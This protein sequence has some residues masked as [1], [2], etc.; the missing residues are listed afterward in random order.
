MSEGED[1]SFEKLQIEETRLHGQPEVRIVDT[2]LNIKSSE[3]SLVNNFSDN[4]MSPEQNKNDW[5]QLAVTELVTN[6]GPEGRDMVIETPLDTEYAGV[7]RQVKARLYVSPDRQG[8]K[9]Y[10]EAH[11]N[12]TGDSFEDNKW[13][14]YKKISDE[15]CRFINVELFCEVPN[16]W[17]G[18]SPGE[19]TGD[20]LD[21]KGKTKRIKRE[22][23]G[24]SEVK[25]QKNTQGE[26]VVAGEMF[27]THLYSL[28]DRLRFKQDLVDSGLEYY[29]AHSA[30]E[31]ISNSS[32]IN[33]PYENPGKFAAVVGKD[34]RGKRF[35]VTLTTLVNE[36]ATKLGA[37]ERAFP[38]ATPDSTP[39]W[40][41]QG[42][43]LRDYSV[44][45]T[46]YK[47]IPVLKLGNNDVK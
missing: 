18:I 20:I 9:D 28:D 10:L 46:D 34:F 24:L 45:G 11:P 6:L 14:I 40:I 47:N 22:V 2:P 43:T 26:T 21:E 25:L 4:N 38:T 8:V 41:K 27:P 44:N 17:E 1:V 29:T 19:T 13:M 42:A 33:S 15:D 37:K 12:R 35:G 7:M 39:F 5:M 30:S 23:V 36:I 3:N 16:H 32:R 31:R